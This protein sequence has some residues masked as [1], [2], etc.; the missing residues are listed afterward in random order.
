MT[1]ATPAL[2]RRSRL[3]PDR[4]GIVGVP[5]A[6]LSTSASSERVQPSAAELSEQKLC[7]A[8]AGDHPPPGIT[9]K[10]PRTPLL[11]PAF[12]SALGASFPTA[13][14][15]LGDDRGIGGSSA[16]PTHHVAAGLG[17]SMDQS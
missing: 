7:A 14:R 6:W 16:V 10:T 11:S 17:H 2:S 8:H 4:T 15:C 13:T 5:S 9:M 1:R 12:V 3:G